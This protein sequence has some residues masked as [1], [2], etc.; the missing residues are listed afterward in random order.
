MHKGKQS[1]AY[2]KV[3]C[4]NLPL[5]LLELLAVGA[6]MGE[7]LMDMWAFMK[8][9]KKFWLFPIIMW[10]VLLGGLMV[11]TSGSVVA[12]FIYTIF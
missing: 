4:D 7:L 11:L 1:L 9:R 2:T 3:R 6:F 10:L 12:P 5:V 8:E